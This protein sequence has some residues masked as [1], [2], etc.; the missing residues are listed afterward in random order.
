MRTK[1]EIDRDYTEHAMKLGDASYR[2]ACLDYEINMIIAKLAEINKEAKE[3]KDG[4]TV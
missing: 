4:E 1:E 3:L 2:K